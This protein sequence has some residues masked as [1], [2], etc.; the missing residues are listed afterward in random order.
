MREHIEKKNL[1]PVWDDVPTDEDKRRIMSNNES[2]YAD[3][4][5]ELYALEGTECDDG[6]DE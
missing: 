5:G 2:D 4:E 3:E 1:E 6:M